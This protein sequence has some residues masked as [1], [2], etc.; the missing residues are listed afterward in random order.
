MS[1]SATG[2]VEQRPATAARRVF[3]ALPLPPAARAELARLTE[4][5]LA[6][7]APHLRLVDPS[8]YHVDRALLRPAPVR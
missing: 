8:G 1:G 6:A 2:T 7:H 5:A 4:T 3:L